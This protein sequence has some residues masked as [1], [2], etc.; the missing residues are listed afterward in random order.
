MCL[1]S[2]HSPARAAGTHGGE[3]LPS[4]WMRPYASRRGNQQDYGG[5][6]LLAACSLPLHITQ[7]TQERPGSKCAWATRSSLPPPWGEGSPASKAAGPL[8][9]TRSYAPALSGSDG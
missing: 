9:T 7:A 1:Y 3:R 6:D 8:R 5:D 2:Y 4:S